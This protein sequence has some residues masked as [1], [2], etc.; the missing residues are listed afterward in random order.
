ME[1][2]LHPH[3]KSPTA[4]FDDPQCRFRGGLW[5]HEAKNKG[6]F[7]YHVLATKNDN[8]TISRAVAPEIDKVYSSVIRFTSNND[9]IQLTPERVEELA[10][11]TTTYQELV[12]DTQ[13][14]YTAKFSYSPFTSQVVLRPG[15]TFANI[16]FKADREFKRIQIKILTFYRTLG[17]WFAN[18]R[19]LNSNTAYIKMIIV[20]AYNYTKHIG[21]SHIYVFS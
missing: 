1:E 4:P 15:D 18:V 20:D 2:E 6:M 19:E 12:I 9:E 17:V 11:I 13:V 14:P 10:A 3:P 16:A 8:V 5:S 21:R 7:A